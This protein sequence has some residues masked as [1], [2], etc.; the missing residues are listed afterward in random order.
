MEP[1][2]NGMFAQIIAFFAVVA[3]VLIILFALSSCTP[4]LPEV[5][6]NGNPIVLYEAGD[7]VQV[8]SEDSV[9]TATFYAFCG[10]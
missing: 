4:I 9:Y 1:M 3:T 8:K 2:R 10:Y 6:D 7:I 5:D